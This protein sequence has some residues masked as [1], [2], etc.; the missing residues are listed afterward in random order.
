VTIIGTRVSLPVGSGPP[1]S[2][3]AARGFLDLADI[4]D[5]VAVL[6][7]L[8]EAPPDRDRQ[9]APILV[10]QQRAEAMVVE[11]FGIGSRRCL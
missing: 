3:A 5:G 6:E 8:R 11:Q 10:R 4:D 7:A 2:R 9:A 1:I